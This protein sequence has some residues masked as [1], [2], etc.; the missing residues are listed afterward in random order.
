V[1]DDDSAKAREDYVRIFCSTQQLARRLAAEFNAKL[2]ELPRVDP[3]TPKVSFLDCSIYE[4]KDKLTG[5]QKVLVEEKLDHNIWHKWNS[6]N[7]YVSGMKSAPVFSED[8]IHDAVRQLAKVGDLEMIEEGSDSDESHDATDDE[9]SNSYRKG[10][11][12]VFSPFEVAQAFSHFTYLA[13]G[14]KRLVCDLQGVYD[15]KRN[16]LRLSDPVIHYHD[17]FRRDRRCV[18]GKTDRGRKGMAMFFATHKDYCGQL[19]KLA[20]RGFKRYGQ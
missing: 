11:T 7:G 10:S 8:V 12:V 6:N 18:H 20:T 17:Q 3:K 5:T 16:E 2:S 14:K 15:E 19:C 9:F 1:L 13:T 4:L